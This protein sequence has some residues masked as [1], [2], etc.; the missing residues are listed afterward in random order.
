MHIYSIFKCL[1]DTNGEAILMFTSIVLGKTFFDVCEKSSSFGHN[2]I[3]DSSCWLLAL[4]THLRQ[5]LFNSLFFRELAIF[6]LSRL[7]LLILLKLGC[8]FLL[9][10]FDFLC[11]LGLDFSLELLG[12][13]LCLF[14]CYIDFGETFFW[15]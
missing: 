9:L 15:S 1:F 11:F 7:L 14:V 6:L 5:S 13:V 12:T 4:K 3:I 10:S 8:S 2:V